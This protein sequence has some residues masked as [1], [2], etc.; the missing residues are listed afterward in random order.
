[1]KLI[2]KYIEDYKKYLLIS[3]SLAIF[4]AFLL[5]APY[6]FLLKIIRG[7]EY[8]V[9]VKGAIISGLCVI[10]GMAMYFFSLWFSHVVGFRIEKNIRK[11][12]V[13]KLL[14]QPLEFFDTHDSG[15]VRKTVDENA[16]LTHTFVAHNLPDIVVTLITPI[17]VL[18]LVISLNL[19][20]GIV[21]LAFF[22][23]SLFLISKMIGN[24]ENVT[25]YMNA[26]DTMT[27]NAV[28]FSRGFPLVK[29]FNIPIESFKGFKKSISDYSEWALK[30]AFDLRKF[31]VLDLVLLEIFPLVAIFFIVEK[32]NYPVISIL[33]FSVVVSTQLT[34]SLAKILNIG[35]SYATAVQAIERVEGIFIEEEEVSREKKNNLKFKKIE[36]KNMSFSYD[37]TA[38]PV[39][40]EINLDLEQ[41]KT[42]A[43]VGTSGSGKTTLAK[44]ISGY[45]KTFSGNILYDRVKRQEFTE[46]EIVENIAYVF[47]DSKLFSRS[48]KENLIIGNPGITEN[49]LVKAIEQT[50]CIDIIN[51]LPEGIDTIV[52]KKGV[53]FS[54]GERQRLSLCRAYV[55][56]SSVVVLDEVTSAVD[57]TNDVKLQIAIKELVKN[58]I[59]III[60]H[61]LSQ[62]KDADVIVVMEK[63]KILDKGTHEELLKSSKK[64]QTMLTT[65]SES[66]SWSL[67]GG[68]GND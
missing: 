44:L 34:T 47:Q 28:E 64:Y 48:V 30:F 1:M 11:F 8:D 57:A 40:S 58:R 53:T 60:A 52:G 42:Y 55:K 4:S 12:G 15:S 29:L 22:L 41:G 36:I 51:K 33:V 49:D 50:Q 27:S 63:G 56:D 20:L 61:K 46:K 17:L 26:L 9:F 54:G 10:I 68:E 25:N 23:V 16:A 62:I 59:G 6:I 2:I 21:L 18:I 5:L 65:S 67:V 7:I 66:L 24:A 38:K 32:N 39:L 45:Y 14:N 13:K 35:T 19:S 31:Y 43:F 3:F 37:E